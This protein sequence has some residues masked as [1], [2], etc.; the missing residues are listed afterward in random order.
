MTTE[1]WLVPDPNHIPVQ[2]V[3][4]EAEIPLR[5]EID[6]CYRSSED[7]NKYVY[8]IFITNEL[9]GILRSIGQKMHELPAVELDEFIDGVPSLDEFPKRLP[10]AEV[11]TSVKFRIEGVYREKAGVM[12]SFTR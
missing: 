3:G 2:P 4:V 5:F 12:L 11:N 9:A 10:G 6:A 1:P 7:D 8:K